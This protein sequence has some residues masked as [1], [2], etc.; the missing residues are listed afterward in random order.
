MTWDELLIKLLAIQKARD[1]PKNWVVDRLEDC[2]HPPR[3]IWRKLAQA[4]G[5][6]KFW[7]DWRHLPGQETEE[8]DSLAIDWQKYPEPTPTPK[9]VLKANK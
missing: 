5:F 1:L 2:G 8:P 3:A 4:L 7:A 9:P 6:T